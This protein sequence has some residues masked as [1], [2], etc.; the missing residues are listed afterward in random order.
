MA[1]DAELTGA[2]VIVES[3]LTR[4]GPVRIGG[5]HYA[6]E[7]AEGRMAEATSRVEWA[8]KE[9]TEACST[10]GVRHEVLREIG[11]PFSLMIDQSRYHDL[12]VFGLKSLFEFDIVDDPHNAPV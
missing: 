12:M 7:L 3:R 1:R 2:S 10:A 9:F 6:L 4:I 8:T 11:E 5:G